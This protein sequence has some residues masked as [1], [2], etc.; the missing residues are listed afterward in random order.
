MRCYRFVY[1]V[2][3]IIVFRCGMR[4]DGWVISGWDFC[5]RL[6]IYLYHL[7]GLVTN[8]L[9]ISMY[10]SMRLLKLRSLK[11]QQYFVLSEYNINMLI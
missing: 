4:N 10:L 2:L 3:E 9:N 5:L 7:T 1:L 8:I 6:S 11:L